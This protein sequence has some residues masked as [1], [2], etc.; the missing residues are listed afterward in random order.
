MQTIKRRGFGSLEKEK[1]AK[2]E[3]LAHMIVAATDLVEAEGRILKSQLLRVTVAIFAALLSIVLAFVGVGFF[4]Y[5][6]FLL[7][8]RSLTEPVAIMI[9]GFLTA[10]LSFG[11]LWTAKTVLK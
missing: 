10:A 3:A 8:S 4:L 11:A 1:E 2:M 5:G 9:F 6:F 7:I